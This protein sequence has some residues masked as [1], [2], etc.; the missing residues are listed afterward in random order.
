MIHLLF[1][2]NYNECLT[3]LCLFF[4]DFIMRC[5]VTDLK[6]DLTPCCMGEQNRSHRY[7]EYIGQGQKTRIRRCKLP[8][9]GRMKTRL[10]RATALRARTKKCVCIVH[11]H[12]EWTKW[13]FCLRPNENPPAAENKKNARLRMKEALRAREWKS[14]V[15]TADN[16]TGASCLTEGTSISFIVFSE[17][18]L[19]VFSYWLQF[20]S[21]YL[22]TY[23]RLN[24]T[25][26]R[27][28]VF[29]P[30]YDI[31]F[32][33]CVRERAIYHTFW[34]RKLFSWKD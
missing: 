31:F 2:Y 16:I 12:W 18:F 9:F 33:F 25:F 8:A 13:T 1:S 10:L 20:I 11:A 34:P 30:V 3:S 4:I 15:L 29:C 7:I 6:L 22:Q 14:A 17:F 26:C 24:V 5:Y 19:F 23:F 21:F 27:N 28:V 32:C